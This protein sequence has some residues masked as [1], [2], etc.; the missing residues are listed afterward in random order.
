MKRFA[1]YQS[2]HHDQENLE[3]GI[4]RKGTAIAL[5]ARH[6]SLKKQAIGHLRK[7]DQKLSTVAAKDDAATKVDLVAEALSDLI[8]AQEKLM[9]MS[10]TNI[11]VAVASVVLSDDLKS[12]VTA[13]LKGRKR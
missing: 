10:G 12:T 8:A 11:S 6:R 2:P 7:A 1:E 9:E 4:V 3:E 5:G 13:A